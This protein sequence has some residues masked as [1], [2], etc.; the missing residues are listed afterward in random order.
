M[1]ITETVNNCFIYGNLAGL[2]RQPKYGH[3]KELHM[4]IKLC[5]R[6]LVSANPVVTSLGRYEQVGV[7]TPQMQMLS[8]NSKSLSWETYDEDIYSLGDSTLITSNGLLEH[9]NVTRD[10][11]DYL[12]Y[13]TSVEVSLSESFL[14]GGEWP[15]LS[16]ES[17]GHAMHVFINGQLSGSAHGTRQNKKFTFTG[18]INLHAGTNRIAL[19]AAQWD[20]RLNNGAHFESWNAGVLG[21]VVI[22]G[23]D[24][25]HRDLTWQRWSYQIGLKGEA[26]NLVSLNGISSVEWTQTSLFAQKQQPLTWYKAYINPPDGDEPLAL[27]MG[28]MGKGQPVKYGSMA[29]VLGDIG[30]FMQMIIVNSVVIPEHSVLQNVKLAVDNLPKNGIGSFL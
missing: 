24:Q 5:E 26:M 4:A 9:L 27:D 18:K 12:W 13:I 28:S 3:L 20:C 19:L 17:K 7:Q 8:S 25:G 29:R 23:I 11:S 1:C 2:I 6:A 16:V 15:T 10:M 30:L 22:H 14:N 21:P